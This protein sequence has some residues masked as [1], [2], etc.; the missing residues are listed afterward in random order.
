MIRRT[1]SKHIAQLA[2]QFSAVTLTGPRQSGK[3]T[4]CRTLFSDRPYANLEIPD[5]RRFASE[6]PRGFLAGFPDGGVLDEIQR[7]P[8]LLS[9]IQA[10]IDENR[11]HPGRW[12]LTGSQNLL[13]LESVG[14]TLAGRAAIAHLYPLSYGETA[15]ATSGERAVD[16]VLLDGGFP[17]IHLGRVDRTAWFE[18]YLAT[19]VERDVRQIQRIVDLTD[20]DRFVRLCAGRSGQLLNVSSLAS[21]AGIRHE[22]ANAWL[23]VLEASFVIHRLPPYFSNP[24]KR[25]VKRPKLYLVDS[26]L[27]CHLLGIRES[28]Q[29][30]EHP[31]R[32][33]I[34][35]T[36]VVGEFLR[37]QA[38]L[39]LPWRMS[40]YRDRHGTEADIVI[41]DGLRLILAETK[42]GMTFQTEMART[43]RRIGRD[44][45]ERCEV[46]LAVIFGGD[47]G[48]RRSDL[49]VLSW[50]ELD[51][52]PWLLPGIGEDGPPE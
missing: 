34:F 19:Y 51:T 6:D 44:L 14:Q 37:M 8:D 48:Q 43:I 35:E 5:Q 2:G 26:G 25:L 52:G 21:D 27:L 41:E 42:I 49:S 11:R 46:E 10:D 13:L 33:S 39:S 31:L 1:I 7:A 47:R 50:R 24:N 22:T 16:S 28:R 23:S 12:I 20:F 3:T 32:G 17:E 30:A 18:S 40:F 29:L 9:Y 45:E 36:W 4:L 15:D 38:N